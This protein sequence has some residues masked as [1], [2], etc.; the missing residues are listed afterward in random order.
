MGKILLITFRWSALLISFYKRWHESVV[1]ERMEKRNI[2]VIGA[3]AG[4][5]EVIKQIVQALPADL[6]ASIFIVW[7][8]APEV[9][10]I[11]PDVI[12]AIGT[13]PAKHAEDNEVI[14]GNMIYV[15]PPDHH[16]VLEKGLIRITRGPRENRFRPAVDPLFRSAAMAYG[17]RVVGII[18][19]GALD[20]GTAGLKN[21]KKH[22]GIAIVQDP[23]DASV[24]GMPASAVRNV[25]VDH[26]I[27]ASGIA[28]L[29]IYYAS[30]TATAAEKHKVHESERLTHEIAI[31]M[32]DKTNALQLFESGV[33]TPFTCPECHG[34]LASIREDNLVR[35]RCHTGHSFTG[36][37]LLAELS[38]NIEATLW[39]AIRS[40]QE[41]E[42]L[43]NAIGD[44]YAHLNDAQLAAAYFRKAKEASSRVQLLRNIV[45]EHEHLSNE[46]LA[47]D[48]GP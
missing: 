43:L 29:L 26:I 44:H 42:M 8:I 35:F 1:S 39:T 34:V 6:D 45:R 22:G 5:F 9:R 36:D 32:D 30:T 33:L 14:A 40:V 2:L 19:S 38:D 17:P 15:A 25:A 27:P 20:D 28:D 37:S 31:A 48:T 21:V 11:L 7:H 47:G 24:A 4:G 16:L 3:S 18:L 10:G 46:K 41:S 12:N 23:A 13:I